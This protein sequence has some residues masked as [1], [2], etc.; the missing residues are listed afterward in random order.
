MTNHIQ[1]VRGMR[2]ILMDESP[3]W[4]DI[5]NKLKEI[6]YSY[7][8]QQVR[9]PLLESTDLFKRSIGE[10]T[11]IVEK[12]MYTF[13][14]RN[15]DRLTMRPEGT[16]SCIRA[17]IQHGFLYNQIQRVWYQ[18]PMFRHERPQKGRYRQFEQFGM[19]AFGMQGIHIE[20]ELL[21]ASWRLW[22]QLG[23]SEFLV[24]SINDIGN[25]KERQHYKEVLVQYFEKHIDALDEDSKRRLVSNPLRIL[26]SK[27]PDMQ[28]LIEQSPKIQDYLAKETQDNFQQLLAIL[29]QL[30]IPY[31]V[32]PTLVRGL[33]Y[34]NNLVFE[35]E[36]EVLGAQGTVCAGGRYDGLVEW[37]G[38]NA[39]PAV[40]FA[41]GLDRVVM[42]LQT[43]QPKHFTG[44]DLMVMTLDDVA[45]QKA[46]EI[47]EFIR[48]RFPKLNIWLNC[49]TKDLKKQLKIADRMKASYA[50][51]LGP[52]EYKNNNIIFKSLQNNSGQRL[53]HITFDNIAQSNELFDQLENIINPNKGV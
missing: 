13:E 6:A 20:A 47:T 52:E 37:L 18:G 35:W 51:I 19:E 25:L 38:G 41:I 23:L 36:T 22:Q 8:Y 16:A 32:K 15:G 46:L 9:L 53:C 11:D 24:L 7:G 26:D 17:G 14:D 48:S 34:Y 45:R 12:E 43:L 33:D 39:T 21:I 2:D 50:L 27:V 28:K 3:Y 30:K 1:S 4:I 40:G 5:E 49:G 42:L 44:P 31:R 29:D 10:S